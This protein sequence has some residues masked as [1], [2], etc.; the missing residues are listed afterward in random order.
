MQPILDTDHSKCIV[1]DQPFISL[2]K[3]KCCTEKCRSIH[4]YQK[5]K[6][7]YNKLT[8]QYQKLRATD[9]KKQIIMLKGGKCERCGYNRNYSALCL[10]HSDPKIKEFTLDSRTL[11]STTWNK[12]F[13][14]L[15]KCQLL[16]ANCHSEVHNPDKDIV[17]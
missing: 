4:K 11:S 9:R 2:L 14:E 3:A 15:E 8:Y 10:H 6:E 1:C 5:N 12:I 7:R 16:C 13:L 17:P